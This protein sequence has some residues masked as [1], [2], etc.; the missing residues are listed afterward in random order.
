MNW[1]KVC[2]PESHS[3]ESESEV[4]V[5]KVE[6]PSPYG[7]L[8]GKLKYTKGTN[9]RSKKMYRVFRNIPYALP[10][11][12]ENRFGQSKAFPD[13]HPPLGTK[14]VPYD[15]SKTGPLCPQGE[16]NPDNIN[17]IMGKN[18]IELIKY[19]MGL[20]TSRTNRQI[21]IDE[22]EI[23]ALVSKLFNLDHLHLENMTLSETTRAWLDVDFG[24]SEDCLHLTISTPVKPPPKES[25]GYPVM[26]FIHG[27]GFSSGTHLH[28]EADRLGDAADVI[29]VAINYRVGIL[30]FLCLDSDESAGNQGM[31]DI[32]LALEWVQ[33]YIEH[34]GGDKERV[35]IFGE[36][37]GSATIGHL[38]LSPSTREKNLFKYGIGQS[39]SAISP[40]AFD[41]EPR[42]SGYEF[43]ERLGCKTS[44]GNEDDD[45]IVKCLRKFESW[46]LA[47]EFSLLTSDRRKR[48]DLGFGGTSP[49]AQT[50]GKKVFYG[51]KDDP[52][53]ILH[54]GEYNTKI[55]ILFGNNLYEGIYAYNLVYNT[56]L[57]PNNLTNKKPESKNYLK[58]DFLDDIHRAVNFKE[59]YSL[60]DIIIR[61]YFGEDTDMSN[62][63]ATTPGL[64]DYIGMHLLKAS[65]YYMMSK[66]VDNNG[67]AF[68][69][70]FEHP[71]NK[72]MCHLLA[73]LSEA[74]DVGK[75]GACHADELMYMFDYEIPLVLCDI[76]EFINNA[77][78]YISCC[79]FNFDCI[80]KELQKNHSECLYGYLTEEEQ[81][82]LQI[83]SQKHGLILQSMG[84]QMDREFLLYPLGL[85]KKTIVSG[86][87]CR[88]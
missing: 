34:F 48:M 72:S 21:R 47:T 82:W 6:L 54:K 74:P 79:D 1:G 76:Q 37:A 64:I 20:F 5:L 4:D 55:P 15:A 18:N 36:S 32:L 50:K 17:E 40:W 24:M 88:K 30:G 46:E 67:E 13:D 9:K 16:I 80:I 83:Q 25:K 44:N 86:D 60:E 61:D 33:K 87:R 63:K 29:V 58:Y 49:C 78:D 52:L 85:E 7:F 35:T 19:I 59:G 22:H 39:G 14:E 71:S 41:K 28:N 56:F 3:S 12:K 81:K 66:H 23:L 38:L 26:F 57:K 84:T 31:L 68:W 73:M 65:T 62:L 43:A 75:Y 77:V 45:S 10:I 2:G 8:K 69:Y 51:P 27:G 42:R 70:S 53:E 11:T